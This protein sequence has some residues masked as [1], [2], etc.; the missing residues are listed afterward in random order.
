MSHAVLIIEDEALIGLDLEALVFEEADRKAAY[1]LYSELEFAALTR[2][3]ADAADQTKA[4]VTVESSCCW[5]S[6][7]K[8]P[9]GEP[10]TRNAASLLKVDV[11]RSKE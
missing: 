9:S 8:T 4:A 1:E 11:A 10:I 3:Y 2:E 5:L 6:E 7:L